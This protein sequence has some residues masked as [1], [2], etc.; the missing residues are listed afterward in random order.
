VLKYNDI[1]EDDTHIYL[2]RNPET[3]PIEVVSWFNM[4]MEVGYDDPN[5]RLIVRRFI[6]PKETYTINDVKKIAIRTFDC[7]KCRQG[8]PITLPGC[9][10]ILKSVSSEYTRR[11]DNEL[12]LEK[13][14]GRLTGRTGTIAAVALHNVLGYVSPFISVGAGVAMLV[15]KFIKKAP[16]SDFGNTVMTSGLSQIGGILSGKITMND[17]ISEKIKSFRRKIG[18][19]DFK[20]L[21]RIRGLLPKQSNSDP[22]LIVPQPAVSNKDVLFGKA[23]VKMAKKRKTIGTTPEKRAAVW[24]EKMRVLTNPNSGHWQKWKDGVKSENSDEKK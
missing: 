1:T 8:V 15:Y 11:G 3:E 17:P 5:K 13:L 22:R 12:A 9:T 7:P 23:N 20:L 21:E 24:S 6:Y 10:T 19:A 14:K 18:M 2:W 4:F 16:L